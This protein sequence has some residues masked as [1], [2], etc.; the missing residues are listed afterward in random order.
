MTTSPSNPPDSQSLFGQQTIP[1]QRTSNV[2]VAQPIT[3][4]IPGYEIRRQIG[5]GGMGVVFE[6]VQLSLNRRVAVKVLSP[7]LSQDKELIQRFE[8]EGLILG[9]LSHPHIVQVVERGQAAGQL[10]IVLEFVAGTSGFPVTLQHYLERAPIDPVEVRRLFLEVAQALAHAHSQGIVHRDVKPSNVLLDQHGHVKVTDFGIALVVDSDSR[11]TRPAA[12]LGTLEYMA[13]EQRQNPAGADP[14]SDIYSLGVMLYELLTGHLPVG[15]FLM[16]ADELPGLANEWNALLGRSLQ[17]KPDQRFQTMAEFIR[18]LQEIPVVPA[19]TSA[20]PTPKLSWAKDVTLP[21]PLPRKYPCTDC[22]RA[23]GEEDIYCPGCSQP[24]VWDCPA[25]DRK[26]QVATRF[27]AGCGRD[28]QKAVRAQSFLDRAL[29]ICHELA[30]CADPLAAGAKA[31][32]A[33]QTW[34]TATALSA[35]LPTLVA[36]TDDFKSA[37]ASTL[38]TAARDLARQQQCGLAS[39]YC[40]LILIALPTHEAARDLLDRLADLREEW[41]SKAAAFRSNGQISQELKTLLN[42]EQK[43]PE[44]AV[45]KALRVT[46]EAKLSSVKSIVREQIP[47]LQQER[48]LVE[49]LKVLEGIRHSGVAVEGLQDFEATQRQRLQ[50]AESLLNTARAAIDQGAFA[51]AIQA[52]DAARDLVTDHAALNQLHETSTDRQRQ[53]TILRDQLQQHLKNRRWFRARSCLKKMERGRLGGRIPES[54]A[55]QLTAQ[56]LKA[57][58]YL[59][60]GLWALLSCVVVVTC[61]LTSVLIQGPLA[62]FVRG[63]FPAM[64]AVPDAEMLT[65]LS[66][67]ALLAFNVPA[68]SLLQ[69]PLKEPTLTG[70]HL[71]RVL[72]RTLIAVTVAAVPILAVLAVRDAALPRASPKIQQDM[73]EF[74]GLLG[75]FAGRLG[76]LLVGSLPLGLV[77]ADLAVRWSDELVK[78]RKFHR[79]WPTVLGMVGTSGMSLLM[80][81]EP[82]QVSMASFLLTLSGL[83]HITGICRFRSVLLGILPAIAFNAIAGAWTTNTWG[84]MTTF[85]MAGTLF[86]ALTAIW[87]RSSNIFAFTGLVLLAGLAAMVL[88]T[89]AMAVM[90]V[91]IL[92]LGEL[93]PDLRREADCRLHLFDRLAELGARYRQR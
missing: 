28:L 38:W 25:C 39:H 40:Q 88:P 12:A 59:R 42:L 10:F 41:L 54:I 11:L 13:P 84:S 79:T 2:G 77:A 93:F 73:Q 49:L 15:L 87:E 52:M 9:R 24:L 47:A 4:Q 26:G 60:L 78:D 5:A 71:P 23:C 72:L 58:T 36:A 80:N 74:L 46:C 21:E 61:S 33:W 35:D 8:Q 16:P 3:V 69:L 51:R 45:I 57:N 18:E 68:L 6:A 48:R 86:F 64:K 81:Y 32:N 1:G 66:G 91:W 85:A 34:K 50:R 29:K 82:Q 14:R 83:T 7:S 89:H 76:L 43:F 90:S 37:I 70:N 22:G 27:C 19:T 65:A 31:Q 75:P 17:S 30:S 44:D 20:P 92:L 53:A 62:N 56:V 63:V 67:T 55:Q